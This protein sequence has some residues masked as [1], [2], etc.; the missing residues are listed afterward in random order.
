[1]AISAA[2]VHACATVCGGEIG[3][4]GGGGRG[5]DIPDRSRA[6]AAHEGACEEAATGEQPSRGPGA[7]FALSRLLA[8][9]VA[10]GRSLFRS[11]IRLAALVTVPMCANRYESY[12]SHVQHRTIRERPTCYPSIARLLS[13]I[14]RAAG[15]EGPASTMASTRGGESG[16][17]V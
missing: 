11:L 12:T 7:A 1:M 8:P 6:V 14:A 15:G 5:R 16:A 10:C 4:E 17:A 9:A 3:R 13:S 2:A